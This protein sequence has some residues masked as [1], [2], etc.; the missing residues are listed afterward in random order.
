M[1][2]LWRGFGWLVPIFLVV[3]LVVGAAVGTVLWRRRGFARTALGDVALETLAVLSGLGVVAVTLVPDSFP[4]SGGGPVLELVP[5]A[6]IGGMFDAVWWQVPLVQ[7][8]GNV[9][10][11]VPGTLA[12]AL[13]FRWGVG[14][15]LLAGTSAAVL[16]EALQLVLGT[17]RVTSTDDV[18]LAALGSAIGGVVA[19]AWHE[20]RRVRLRLPAGA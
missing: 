1:V 19:V 13:R 15:T 6:L 3:G 7:L 8:G 10:L 20:R 12:L 18:L 17:G 2:Q 14:R 5:F 16:V 4:P 11:W 9:L